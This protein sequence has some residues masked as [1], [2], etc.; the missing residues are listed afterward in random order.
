MQ[1]PIQKSFLHGTLSTSLAEDVFAL[2][3]AQCGL[4]YDYL[5][6]NELLMTEVGHSVLIESLLSILRNLGQKQTQFRN[7]FLYELPSCVAAANDFFRLAERVERLQQST[8]EQYSHLEW[9]SNGDE[10]NL[11]FAFQREVSIL[12]DT[13]EADAVYAANRIA[14]F[15]IQGLHRSGVSTQLFSHDWEEK[16]VQNEVATSM[17]RT[18]EEYLADIRSCVEQDYLFHKVVAALVRSTVC[19][20]VQCF[21]KKAD[22]RR[23]EMKRLPTIKSIRNHEFLNANRAI[24]RM[25]YDVITLR[26]YFIDNTA[27]GDAAL[28]RIIVN[29]FS[30]LILLMECM[31]LAAGK[32]GSADSLEEFVV[33]VHKKTGAN[34]NVTRQFLSDLFVLCGPKNTHRDVENTVRMM[35]TELKLVSKQMKERRLTASTLTNETACLRLDETL[36]SLYEDRM[37]QERSSLCGHICRDFKVLPIQKSLESSIGR[38]SLLRFAIKKEESSK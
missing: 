6:S 28:G 17:T 23:Q 33:V 32:D 9:E 27:N 20:Y 14:S 36:R 29:E 21:V 11:T 7:S 19:F 1:R 15:V 24:C 34:S 3:E 13:L 4:L 25:N 8:V 16:F 22:N 18:F 2:V 30:V 35:D 5:K 31:H 26:D 37:L 10:T 12:L 38:R